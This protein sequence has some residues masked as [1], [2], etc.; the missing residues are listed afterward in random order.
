M[1]AHYEGD[2]FRE[3]FGPWAVIAGG[4]DGIGGAFAREAAARGLDHLGKGPNWVPGEA[5]QAVARGLWPL[6]RVGV[7]NGMT[8]ASAGLF[9]LPVSPVE[10]VEFDEGD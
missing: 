7:I 3:R 1:A 2:A 5:N 9:G 4:S 6:P 8:E 10:G